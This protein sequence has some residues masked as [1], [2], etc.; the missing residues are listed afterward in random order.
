MLQDL[1]PRP[2][3]FY[4]TRNRDTFTLSTTHTERGKHEHVRN[5]CFIWVPNLVV[6]LGRNRRIQLHSLNSPPQISRVIKSRT[7]GTWNK[8]V[9]G[10]CIHSDREISQLDMRE[11]WHTRGNY[12]KMSLREIGIWG[13]V[14]FRR[15]RKGN[16]SECWGTLRTSHALSLEY[17]LFNEVCATR[18]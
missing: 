10:K 13:W 17:K 5:H 12:I 18:K 16:D 2:Y 14:G 15:L 7:G 3:T 6:Y 8:S 4:I 9:N 11:L 1:S